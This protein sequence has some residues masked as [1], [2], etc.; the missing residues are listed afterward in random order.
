MHADAIRHSVLFLAELHLRMGRSSPRNVIEVPRIGSDLFPARRGLD[1]TTSRLHQ[2]S[3]F[4][5]GE[6]GFP[7]WGTLG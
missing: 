5:H 2:L 1:S 3:H 4:P 7:T 6:G